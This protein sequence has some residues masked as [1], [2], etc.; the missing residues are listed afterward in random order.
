MFKIRVCYLIGIQL[1]CPVLTEQQV[2][3]FGPEAQE[4]SRHSSQAHQARVED[5]DQE[6]NLQTAQEPSQ[7]VRC[8]GLI[9]LFVSLRT[10]DVLILQLL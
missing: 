7:I 1:I 2:Q 3:A 10:L 8:Q 9:N 5:Q 4:D 6:G